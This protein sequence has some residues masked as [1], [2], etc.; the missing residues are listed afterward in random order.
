MTVDGNSAATATGMPAT[1]TR[2]ID[3]SEVCRD[4]GAMRAAGPITLT[5][6]EGEFVAI[7]GPSGCGKS[8]LLN[9]VAGMLR[10]SAGEVRYRGTPVTGPNRRVGYITQK[11]YLLPWR[12]VRNNIML[13]L[14]FRKFPKDEAR[15]IATDV[16]RQM[17]LVGFEDAF[18]AQL[19]GGMA[20]RVAIG[21]TLAY[22]PEAYLMDEPFASLDAQLRATMHADLMRLWETTGSTFV[23]VTHDLREAITLA[24]RVIV[25][26]RRPGLV[27]VDQR[28]DLPRPR[29]VETQTSEEFSRYFRLLWRALDA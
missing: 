29:D 22:G 16:I 18:P 9:M 25:M 27:T 19:S 2:L 6:T 14:Q 7:V 20:Q 17:D 12:T 26:S 28:I 15:R 3:F 13:P 8:T 10:P 4:F 1:T 21:R 5:V 24:D 23:F 11:N